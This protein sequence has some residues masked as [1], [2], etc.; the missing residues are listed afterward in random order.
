M[1]LFDSCKRAIRGGRGGEPFAFQTAPLQSLA[2]KLSDGYRNADPFP[3]VVIDDFMEI[4]AAERLLKAFPGRNSPI[5]LD[6][7]DRDAVHQPKK[8][9]IGH[10]ERLIGVSPWLQNALDAFNSYPFLSFLERLTGIGKLLPDPY[11]HGGGLHQILSGGKLDVHADFN[12]LSALDLFRRINV[13]FYLNK[14][15]KP[16]YQG[17]LELWDADMTECRRKVAPIFNRMVIFNTDKS[18]FHGHPAPLNTPEHVT[19]K[20][21]ALYYYTARPAP[22]HR[23]DETTDWQN[24]DVEIKGSSAESGGRR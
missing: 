12:D 1:R 20:S 17:N 18:S 9:G 5:W 10:A 22:G 13:L 2:K 24:V 23:Y 8:L 6:W 7:R 16:E 19:R 3:H 4:Q 14:S 15:W 11:F 21:L